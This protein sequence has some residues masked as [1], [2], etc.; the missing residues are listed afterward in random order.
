MGN[1]LETRDCCCKV[2]KSVE[3]EKSESGDG[4]KSESVDGE[5]EVVQSC[6]MCRLSQRLGGKLIGNKTKLK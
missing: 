6:W 1:S 5:E 4:E 3:G 2:Q